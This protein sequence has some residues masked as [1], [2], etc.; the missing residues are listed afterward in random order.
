METDLEIDPSSKLA[1][2]ICSKL[3]S[4][5]TLEEIME[6][7]AK[8]K[9]KSVYV[10]VKRGK[11]DSVRLVV[12]VNGNHCYRCDD[13]LLIPVPKKFVLLEP[14]KMY[15]EMTLKANIFLALKGAKERDLYH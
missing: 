8:N 12:D 4:T 3:L 15:F 2:I 11:P 14:D 13:I 7:V 9:D 5:Y 1:D 10:Y 6:T